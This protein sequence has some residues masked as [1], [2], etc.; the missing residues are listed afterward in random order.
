MVK[1][2]I[3][4]FSLLFIVSLVS[5][6]GLSSRVDRMQVGLGEQVELTVTL[7]G[8]RGQ[9]PDTREL[10]KNFS[11]DRQS[12]STSMQVINGVVS[13]EAR[14]TF[15]ISP[16][17][18]GKLVIPSLKVGRFS[19]DPI[20]ITVTDMPVAQSTSDDVLME[21]ELS[22][23]N[24]YVN[25]Q[26]AY[27]QR[28]YFSRPLVDSASISKP[29]LSKGDADIQQWGA[30]DP[31]YVTHNNRPYQLIERYYL[32]YPR[33]SGTLEFEPSVFSGSLA[34]S[35]QRDNFQMNGFRRGT[36]VNAYSEKASVEIK[37]KP[38]SFTAENWLPA[39][40]VTLSMNFSQ[41]IESLS[42]GEPV[43]VTIALIAEGLKAEVLPEVVLDLPDTVKSYP[44]KPAFQTDKV[45]NG[46]VGLRQEKIVLIANEA[47]EYQ[48]PE[49]TI[50]WWSTSE[51]KLMEAKLDAFTLKVTGGVMAPQ[52]I[53]KFS[54][55]A[56]LEKDTAEDEQ[57]TSEVTKSN[58]EEAGTDPA[59]IIQ[60]NKFS[61]VKFYEENKKEI[62][63][64]AILAIGL[65]L[66][67]FLVWRRRKVHLNSNDYKQQV[68]ITSSIK[69]VEA[70]CNKNNL[71]AAVAA[72]PV[73]AAKVGIYPA[74]LA[75]IES[76]GDEQLQLA[77]QELT[78]A[79]YSPNPE[80]WSGKS[81]LAAVKQYS[82]T[83]KFTSAN[84]AGL[85][86]LH[87]M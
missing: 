30:S 65:S 55:Q 37:E 10:L 48:I 64:G 18:K 5:A 66:I 39:S 74:T 69:A 25:S 42:V 81:L 11:I 3:V 72:L 12:Q 29:K 41:P 68:E 70:A 15:L 80:A 24:P 58:Q 19:S 71:R 46:M 43:T 1:R 67:G 51:D 8:V 52:A 85:A 23:E 63:T 61:A 84:E 45:T 44:E 59:A 31:R 56:D 78:A 79:N 54:S 4:F 62:L 57:K 87:P 53:S 13:Q 17:R 73:W 82:K 16:N 47:G 40:R 35:R 76:A 86:P 34:S 22:P 49:V 14:W 83:S 6:K 9:Q 38:A 7:S 32:I 2:F 60:T 50:P 77:I 27:I 26:L 75:G 20:E 21:V 28:L 36:R 33:K